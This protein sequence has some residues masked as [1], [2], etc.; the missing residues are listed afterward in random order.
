[1]EQLAADLDGVIDALAL[2]RP[3]VVA[4]HS[5]GGPIAMA[6]ATKRPADT[7]GVVLIDASS[8]AFQREDIKQVREHYPGDVA[9]NADPEH[10]DLAAVPAQLDALP[11]LGAVPLVVLT[12]ILYQ[13]DPTYPKID[14]DAY[15]RAWVEGQRHWATY[16]DVSEMVSVPNAGHFIHLN[17]L[18]VVIAAV[19]RML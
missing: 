6:W 5:L 1:L 3:L 16:S 17:Q 11:R 4:G 10:L 2:P 12:R 19:L 13:P 7:V 8:A 18:N 9:L 14:W 15:E